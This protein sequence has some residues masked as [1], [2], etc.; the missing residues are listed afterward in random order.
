MS[1]A[2]TAPIFPLTPVLVWATLTAANTAPDGTGVVSTLVTGG[3]S[4]TRV[5]KL[6]VRP[7][8][9]NVA[10]VLRVFVNNGG[11]NATAANNALIAEL[12]CPATNASNSA[13]SIGQELALDVVLP[14]DYR[15]CVTICTA[16]ASGLTV[17]A[18]GGDY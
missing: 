4:G 5:D 7:L 2:N 16:V 10:T 6:R 17:T 14:A 15:L 1:S 9:E 18:E 8:G 11:D 3:A 12:D 13:S